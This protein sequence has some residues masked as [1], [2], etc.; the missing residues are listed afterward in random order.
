MFVP[1]PYTR[2]HT[3]GTSRNLLSL[4]CSADLRS[5]R[6]DL[7]PGVQAK[8]FEKTS[9]TIRAQLDDHR[10]FLLRH[11]QKGQASGLPS[12]VPRLE[13]LQSHTMPSQN[14]VPPQMTAPT[15]NY[16]TAFH[17]RPLQ[18]LSQPHAPQRAPAPRPQEPVPGN[19][20]TY[21]IDL[22]RALQQ[23]AQYGNKYEPDNVYE[24]VV[25]IDSEYM[26]D[27]REVVGTFKRLQEANMHVARVYLDDGYYDSGSDATYEVE[28]GVSLKISVMTDG[29]TGGYTTISVKEVTAMP[30]ARS[31]RR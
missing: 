6:R 21:P 9:D 8:C 30:S 25:E 12:P 7:G 1:Q 2:Q 11:R 28:D 15:N 19:V 16:H 31:N 22:Q 10:A 5:Y 3:S 20:A 4:D 18:I 24:V 23:C 14:A 26:K 13:V 17:P 29:S 27:S